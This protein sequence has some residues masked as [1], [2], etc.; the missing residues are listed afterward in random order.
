MDSIKDAAPPSYMVHV[1]QSY[2]GA[3][4]WLRDNRSTA[5]PDASRSAIINVWR[6]LRQVHRDPF[7]VCD[8]STV[9]DSDLIPMRTLLSNGNGG[10]YAGLIQPGGGDEMELW[11]V[12]RAAEG[13]KQ[14]QWW[15]L[16]EMNPDEVVLLKCFDSDTSRCRRAPHCGFEDPRYGGEEWGARESL[17]VR[18]AVFWANGDGDLE[19]APVKA[20]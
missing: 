15:Y 17:E 3:P 9:P 8:G 1:D 13:K 19:G 18:C 10:R 14:H 2:D 11:V 12:K 16:H 6:P 7:A 4:R 20:A 5:P